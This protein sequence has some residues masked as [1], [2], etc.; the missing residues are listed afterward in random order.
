MRA[1]HVPAGVPT[2]AWLMG[3]TALALVAMAMPGAAVAAEPGP[4]NRG[5]EVTQAG[6]AVDFAIAA[7][8]LDGA[9]TAFGRQSGWQVSVD[10]PVLAG[11]TSPGVNGRMAPRD[12]LAR[13]L[14]GTGVVWRM[15]D[16]RTV[17]L[18][19]AP[20]D[21]AMVLEP[22]TVE[23]RVLAPAQAEIGNLPPAYA[24]GQVARGGR[25]GMLGNRDVM[26]TPFNQSSYTAKTMAD[27]QARS[28]AD[29]AANDASVRA[30]WPGTGYSVPLMIRGFASSNQDFAFNGLYGVVPALTVAVEMAER[31][32]ILKGPNAL[33]VGMAPTGSVGGTVNLVPKRAEDEPLTRLTTSYLSDGQFGGHVDVGRRFGA[34][35]QFGVRFNG[36]Y[37]DGDTAVDDQSQQMGLAVAGLDF[38]GERVR[39]SADLGYQK[40]KLDA[41][42]LITY[43]GPGTPVPKA[44]DTSSNWFQPWSWVDIEDIFGAVRAEAD[45]TSDWTAFAAVGARDTGFE[46]LTYFPTVT[47]AAGDLTGNAAHFKQH[48]VTD[49]QEIGVRGRLTTGPVDHQLTVSGTRFHQRTEGLTR[50]IAG[51]IRSNLYEPVTAAEPA[52]RDF[53]PP[54]TSDS[55][56]SSLAIGDVLSVLDERVQLIGGLR[57]QRVLT[58]NY[59][60]T[61]GAVTT[62]YRETAV[63]PAAG[64][65]VKPWHNVS[66]YGNYIEGLQQGV[67]VGGTY[68][69]AGQVL[70][71]YVS[72]QIEAG[73]K[74][75]WG[76]V[77]TTLSAFRITQPSATATSSTGV[78]GVDGE[79]RNRG[80][81]F[82][83]YGELVP[84]V[85]LLGGV[86]LTDPTLTRTA[87]GTNDGKDAPGVPRWQVNAGAEWDAPFL[88]GLTLSGRVI[89][90]GSQYVDNANTQ[91]IPSWT[92]FDI[93]ARYRIETAGMPITIRANVENLFDRDYWASSSYAPGWLA[94][95]APRTFLLSTTFEF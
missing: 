84:G 74:V 25:V 8:A 61:T 14:A 76:S 80:L 82:Q 38:R 58:R 5:T 7:Q 4:S 30:S 17:V 16:S 94:P 11:R 73:V 27:Q 12:A 78:L 31:V 1:D 88:P 50:T 85:R 26:D 41:P 29:V 51:T 37:R 18:E 75:D 95:G 89:H 49:T 19:P 3:G 54:K 9:V 59:S 60:T 67:V 48:Y 36:L 32:E 79:Q 22:V 83:S 34:D 6:D 2:A 90:T 40:Q 43:V 42:T 93:G 24:G 65:V 69:N 20:A 62:R 81:E 46:R 71:P 53:D 21:G 86:S 57:H 44:P 72:K 28:V 68:A 45:L 23:G 63:T 10:Q 47:N 35:K 92:R 56:L 77:V 55:T 70:P 91:S 39:V 66:L 52:T 33:L 13:L 87:N 64:L 15:T